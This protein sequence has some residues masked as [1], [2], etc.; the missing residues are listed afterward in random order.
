MVVGVIAK[1]RIANWPEEA[2]FL[3]AD[4]RCLLLSRL[5]WGA[6]DARMDR[7]DKMVVKRI[8]RDWKIY[9]GTLAYFGVVNTG[10]SGSVCALAPLQTKAFR[11]AGTLLGR[12]L[13]LVIHTL[14]HL[15]TCSSSSLRSSSRWGTRP[16]RHKY[17]LSP[18]TLWPSCAAGSRHTWPTGYGIAMR[19]R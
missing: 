15:H 8:A 17:A 13:R 7:L 1:L 19:L 2:A 14:T 18:S 9:A 3:D 11:V 16:R 12:H 5:A 6:E 4:E 10:Y